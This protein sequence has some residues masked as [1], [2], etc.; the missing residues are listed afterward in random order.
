MLTADLTSPNERVRRTKLVSATVENNRQLAKKAQ[1]ESQVAARLKAQ[2]RKE[3]SLKRAEKRKREAPEAEEEEQHSKKKKTEGRIIDFTTRDYEY[4]KRL[5][6]TVLVYFGNSKIV[7]L[8]CGYDCM[9]CPA[10]V[11]P[12]FVSPQDDKNQSIYDRKFILGVGKSSHVFTGIR[13]AFTELY[14]EYPADR[15]Y[16]WKLMKWNK[17]AY[18]AVTVN[19]AEDPQV[20]FQNIFS[21]KSFGGAKHLQAV[22]VTD[23]LNS[24]RK[25][26]CAI[27]VAKY[28]KDYT[29]ESI[30]KDFPPGYEL[31]SFDNIKENLQEATLNEKKERKTEDKTSQK[32]KSSDIVKET[33]EQ[34]EKERNE[35]QSDSEETEES[36]PETDEE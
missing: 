13:Q 2:K 10:L 16:D 32:I 35:G 20:L 15:V 29:P 24:V 12:I 9:P 22:K 5:F 8:F 1:I 19:V 23:E 25:M 3:M 28:I 36:Y 14:P 33:F 27:E 6:Q 17:K 11:Y 4:V 34:M 7:G 31:L 30:L 21:S 26:E 18:K